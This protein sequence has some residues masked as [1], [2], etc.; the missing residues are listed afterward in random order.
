LCRA[1]ESGIFGASGENAK[2][3]SVPDLF[4]AVSSE[5]ESWPQKR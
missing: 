4:V 5:T 2:D 3:G 1:A